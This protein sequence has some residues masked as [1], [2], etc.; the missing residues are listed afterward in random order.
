M[1]KLFF[2][3][4]ISMSVLLQAAQEQDRQPRQTNVQR[5]QQTS[6]SRTPRYPLRNTR[7]ELVEDIKRG[8]KKL[9]DCFESANIYTFCGTQQVTRGFYDGLH[10]RVSSIRTAYILIASACNPYDFTDP[11][12]TD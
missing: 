4:L 10:T 6:Q 5:T 3:L 7:R 9:V 1:K 2:L 11:H 12:R 8:C